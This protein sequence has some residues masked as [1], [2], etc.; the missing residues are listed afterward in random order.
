MVTDFAKS[1][2]HI[3]ILNLCIF[4]TKLLTRVLM[5]TISRKDPS[6]ARSLLVND[7]SFA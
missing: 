2:Y 3:W 6:R 4:L 1:T 5:L 7:P